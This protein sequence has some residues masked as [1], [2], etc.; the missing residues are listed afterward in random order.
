MNGIEKRLEKP[1]GKWV[2]ELPKVLRA[3]QTTLRKAKNEM[4][5]F[6]AFDFEVIIPL[7]VDLP[8]IWT[9]A[10]DANHNEEVLAR[11]LDLANERRENA[12]IQMANYQKHLAKTYN[13]KVQHRIFNWGPRPEKGCWKHQGPNRREAWTELERA[14]QNSQARRQR[15]LL[16]QRFIGQTSSKILKF[17]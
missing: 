13:Q 10:Y 2:E 3:Y 17:Q 4:P 5:Y 14:L 7:E 12:L 9:E 6:L 8:T 11:D 1:K 15:R 16:P